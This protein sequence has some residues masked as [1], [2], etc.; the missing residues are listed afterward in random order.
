MDLST[1]KSQYLKM[2]ST[3]QKWAKCPYVEGS[4]YAQL[5]RNVA[6]D[7]YVMA[8]DIYHRNALKAA[9]Y[10]MKVKG[11]DAEIDFDQLLN[12]KLLT[13]LN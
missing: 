6:W 12:V 5:R 2:V 8:R 7:D 1:L 13:S 3:H 4:D 11:V 9:E 10:I